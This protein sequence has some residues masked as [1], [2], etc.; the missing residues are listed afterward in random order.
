M[1]AHIRSEAKEDIGKAAAWHERQR[2]G[3]GDEFL[4]EVSKAL[5]LISDNPGRAPRYTGAPA[6]R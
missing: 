5:T 3:L 1:R 4:D 6:G 2:G